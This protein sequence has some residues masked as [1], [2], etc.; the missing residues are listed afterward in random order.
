MVEEME[1]RNL[2]MA[3]PDLR[4]IYVDTKLRLPLNSEKMCTEN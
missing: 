2:E 1:L 3:T 4:S